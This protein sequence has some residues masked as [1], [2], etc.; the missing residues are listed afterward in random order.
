[1]SD[2]ALGLTLIALL[3]GIISGFNDGGNLLASFTSA[4]VIRPRTAM[5]LL[6]FVPLGPMLLGTAVARTVGVSV[7]DLSGQGEGGFSL[8]VLTSIAVVLASW[9]LGVPTSMTLALVGAMVGWALAGGPHSAV[10]WPGLDR[11][12]IGV[13]VSVLAGGM[14]AFVLYSYFRQYLGGMA[15]ARALQ[16]ARLQLFTAALQA[17]AYGAN[18]MEKTIGLIG[19]ARAMG[20]PL[21]QVEFAG[22][23][24]ILLSFGSFALGTLLGGWRVARHVA[25]GVVRVRPMQA[26]SEQLAA[27]G[28]VALLALAGAPVSSTQTIDGALVGVGASFRASAIRWGAVR[29]LLGS[30]LITLPLSLIIAMM[31]HIVSRFIG[32]MP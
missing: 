5:A 29:R 14:V 16:L 32:W 11:V 24:P 18:D 31:V 25:F 8:I 21:H 3:Y 30:W 13:P 9:R 6:L 27:G 17:F 4:R 10:H 7:I 23:L 12:A 20:S 19:V 1:M 26:F 28:V 15:Y 22:A 2:T